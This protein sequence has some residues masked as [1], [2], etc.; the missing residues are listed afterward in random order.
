MEVTEPDLF[1]LIKEQ[2]FNK[3]YELIKKNKIK[4]L[5]IKD[6][7]Y[8]YFIQL[9]VNYNQ[10]NTIKLLLENQAKNI[11]IDIL[12]TDG[13]TILYNCIKYNHIEL[14]KVLIEY[15]KVNIGIS[16]ID[17]EDRLGLSSLH[18]SII[19]NNYDAF[20]ILLDSGSDP[21]SISKDGNN[22][23]VTCLIYKRNVMIEYLIDNKFLIAKTTITPN[24]IAIKDA[25]KAGEFVAGAFISENK[26]LQIK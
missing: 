26:N 2:E 1:K 15:N 24:K 16:I 6:N 9:M 8:N 10:I 22:S 18:Y 21:Y 4:N 12:D 13:R 25:I 19:F 14:L 3:I 20:K 11:R 7:N 17:I 23:F 5:D